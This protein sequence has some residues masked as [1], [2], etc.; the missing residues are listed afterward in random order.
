MNI[1]RLPQDIFQDKELPSD[2]LIFH[3]YK[4]PAHSFRG[5]CILDGNAVS[6][7]ISGAK[8]MIFA[9]RAVR[10]NSD[11]IHFLSA[12]NC[13][14]S[15]ELDKHTIVESILIFFDNKTLADFYLKYKERIMGARKKADQG[16]EL[17][18]AFK[19]D[20]FILN[21]MSSLEWLLQS[22]GLLSDEMKRL[23]FEELMLYLLEKYPSQLLSFPLSKNKDLEDLEIRKAV[24]AHVITGVSLEELAFICNLSVSTFKRR[25][26]AIYGVAPGKWFLQKKMEWA[27][28]LILQGGERPGEIY[29]KLGY[30]SHSSFSQAFKQYFGVTP[31]ELRSGERVPE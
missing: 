15:M 25:F 9:D 5:K 8:T 13:M 26:L 23:K 19:K 30:E 17:F 18:L 7:V 20:G 10:I 22:G 31:R 3:R 27:K 11:E 2:G 12:G 21:Y 6:L 4:A 28:E 29:D 14:V 16:I 24:E 1:Y